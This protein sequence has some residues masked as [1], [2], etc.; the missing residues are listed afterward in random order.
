MN[1]CP[2]KTEVFF[3]FLENPISVSSIFCEID[4]PFLSAPIT[5]RWYG[6][7]IAFGLT[8]AV[9]FGGRKAYVWK[10]DIN[11]MLDVLIYGAVGGIIGAR[12]YYVFSKWDYY[13]VNPG[14]IF[15]IWHGGLAIYGGLIG[16]ILAALIV[17]KVEKLNILN[18]LDLCGMSFLIGQGIGRWGNFANQEAFGTN[19]SLPWGMYSV[20]TEEY[21][22]SLVVTGA[23]TTVDPTAYVHPTFLYESLWC[24]LSFVILFVMCQKFRK[25]SGQIFLGYGVLY[26]M[27]RFVVEGLRTDSLYIGDTNLRTS[28]V[29]SLV[30]AVASLVLFVIF[31]IKYTKNPKPIEGVDYFNE[32]PLYRHRKKAAEAEK[33]VEKLTEELTVLKAKKD[34][35][36]DDKPDA[37]KIASLE[38]KLKKAQAELS[39]AQEKVRL[40]D[41]KKALKQAK[42]VKAK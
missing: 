38:E 9:L 30:L 25:F 23:D 36:T 39:E 42:K 19:T 1:F 15:Q 35:D 40:Q 33:L 21:L 16:G 17:C 37:R 28:Q 12:L 13:S 22:Q 5:I 27:E 14:E 10:M 20:K 29:L 2:D 6:V 34:A 32:I 11:K 26:G 31:M 7:I 24:L 3:K 8:L 4:L 18:L 41:E